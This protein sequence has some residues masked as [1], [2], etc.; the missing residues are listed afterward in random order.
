MLAVWIALLV[1]AVPAQGGEA[2]ASIAGIVRDIATRLPLAR[3]RVSVDSKEAVTTGDDGRFEFS[4]LAE[5][6]HSISAWDAEQ[7]GSTWLSVLVRANQPASLELRLK[8]G[9]T[10]CGRLVDENKRPVTGATVVLLE[11]QFRSGE[12]NYSPKDDVSVSDEGAFRFERVPAEHDYLILARKAGWAPA[13]YSNSRYLE[14]AEP[15]RLFSGE[16]RTGV[17]IRMLSSATWCIDGSVQPRVD[18][19]RLR[20]RVAMHHSVDPAAF[21]PHP[22]VTGLPVEWKTAE[23][24][25]FHGCGLPAGDYLLSASTEPEENRPRLYDVVEIRVSGEDLHDVQ[26]RLHY[27]LTIEGQV[28]WDAPPRNETAPARLT[29]DLSPFWQPLPMGSVG[30]KIGYGAKAAIPGSFRFDGLPPDD[31]EWKVDNLPEGCYLRSATLGG[32]DVLGKPLRL[33]T[34]ADAGPLRIV[35]A[36]DGGLF[37]ARV[38]DSDNNP[39]PEGTLY[40]IPGNSAS[41]AEL[42]SRLYTAQIEDGRV[43]IETALPP[44]RYLALATNLDMDGTAEQ[45]ARLWHARSKATAVE[46]A[47]GAVSEVTLVFVPVGSP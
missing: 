30:F 42:A 9:G 38:T 20:L 14:G 16:Q 13:Y 11:P 2:K 8:T 1:A 46:V 39:I 5:G 32:V 23:S 40:L 25:S 35:V 22:S 37:R 33:E 45:V 3:A 10:I 18:L 47:P 12:V 19:P 36:G 17:D 44:G 28:S 29:L 21:G 24:G 7:T 43:A 6:R 4:D 15:V 31:Y 27:G 26:L 41:E 34:A